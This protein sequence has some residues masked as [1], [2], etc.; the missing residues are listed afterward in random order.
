MAQIPL[1]KIRFFVTKDSAN[2]LVTHLHDRGDVQII[3]ETPDESL[4]TTEQEQFD[5]RGHAARLES[6]VAFL[7]QYKKES[8]PFRPMFEGTKVVTTEKALHETVREHKTEEVLYAVHELQTRLIEIDAEIKSLNEEERTINA[9]ERLDFPLQAITDTKSTAVFPLH[10]TARELDTVTEILSKELAVHTERISD[11]ALLVVAHQSVKA[12]VEDIVREKEV[13]ILRLP[14]VAETPKEALARIAKTREALEKEHAQRENEAATLSEKELNSLKQV[15]EHA[16][17]AEEKID[18]AATLP[19]STSVTVFDAWVPDTTWNTLESELT[20]TFPAIAFE[21]REL[22]EEEVPPTMIQNHGAAHPFEFI[23]TL[24]GVPTHKD[25]DPTPFLAFFFFIFFGLSLSDVGYGITLMALTGTVLLRYKVL[26]G[27]R[28]L[29]VTLFFGGAGAFLAGILYGGYFGVNA[30]DVHPAL[31]SLQLF[32]PIGNPMPVF[33]LA[34]SMGVVQIMFGTILDIVRTAKNNDLVNGLLDNVPWL[35]MFLILIAFTISQVGILPEGLSSAIANNWH[36]A[37]I[38]AA[39]L[40]SVTKA[41]LGKGIVDMMLKGVL[42]LYGGVNYF[43]D[44]LS[45]SRLLALG[46]ATSALGFSINLIAGI[47]GGD[48]I[49]IGTIFAILILIAG[50]TL[51]ITLSTLSAFIHSS[52]LQ[53]VEFFGKFLQGTG[54]PFQPF[55]RKNKHTILL[56]EKPG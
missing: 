47:V 1:H 17:W 53:Y 5:H 33:Y 8:D 39:V 2:E 41:R 15:A 23:T 56:P 40:I 50:H 28:Q 55:A 18:T 35:L 52:R 4:V 36:Y 45:Y 10:G 43:S 31:V 3:S 20:D 25:L 37:A 16:T 22:T 13:E 21:K 34:L 19:H 51:N 48:G 38:G 49:G 30:V 6:A 46:L 26:G 44:I 24:Y 7:S 27:M 32:D 14:G 11:S 12:V 54:K 9:W 29:L 42:A